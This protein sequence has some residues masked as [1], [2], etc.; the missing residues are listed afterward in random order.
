MPLLM[1]LSAMTMKV[2]RSMT[3]KEK[4]TIVAEMSDSKGDHDKGNNINIV[5]DN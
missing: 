5:I 4:T 1:D 2:T 3:N